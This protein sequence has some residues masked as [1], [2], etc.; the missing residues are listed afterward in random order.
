MFDAFYTPIIT[1][2]ISFYAETVK[3]VCS[4]SASEKHLYRCDC[5]WTVCPPQ[6]F[7]LRCLKHFIRN[8]GLMGF[9]NQVPL[10]EAIV[11]DLGAARAGG[12]LEKN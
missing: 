1:I 6:L 7:P 2:I 3:V 9:G 11:F 12:F 5:L 4:I 8:D 10:H